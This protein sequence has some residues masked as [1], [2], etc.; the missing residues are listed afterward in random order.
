VEHS[1]IKP[2][3]PIYAEVIIRKLSST[4]QATLQNPKYPYRYRVI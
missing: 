3:N 4:M 1:Q 2:A